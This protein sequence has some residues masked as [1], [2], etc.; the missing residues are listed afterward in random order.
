MEALIPSVF[1]ESKKKKKDDPPAVEVVETFPGATLKD[2]RY[3][4]LFDF[5]RAEWEP[6][7]SQA[8]G[9]Q[10]LLLLTSA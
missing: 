10:G 8:R 1:P 6:R 7:V 9:V 4:P 2:V 3:E 5:F